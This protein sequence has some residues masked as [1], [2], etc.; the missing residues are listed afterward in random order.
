MTTGVETAETVLT[1]CPLKYVSIVLLADNAVSVAATFSPAVWSA[2]VILTT[3][4]GH[5][6]DVT[7]SLM[8]PASTSE[9][10][11]AK[12]LTKT[13]CF[14]SL[15]AAYVPPMVKVAVTVVA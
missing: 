6:D 14:A 8:S 7:V 2:T 4:D 1:T 15:K 11:F 12:P 3:T 13:V 10:W 5:A 9:N